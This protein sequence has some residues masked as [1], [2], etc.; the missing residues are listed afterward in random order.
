M[1]DK[2]LP[3]YRITPGILRCVEEIGEALGN[4]LCELQEVRNISDQVTDHQSNHDVSS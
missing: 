2:Y 1:S 4:L 3:Q